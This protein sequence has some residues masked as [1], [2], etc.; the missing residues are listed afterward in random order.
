MKATLKLIKKM[1][2]IVGNGKNGIWIKNELIFETTDNYP[3]KVCISVWGDKINITEFIE[4]DTYAVDFDIES[5][6]YNGKW[7]TDLKAWKIEG[8]FTK[9]TEIKHLNHINIIDDFDILPF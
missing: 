8:I 7:F 1:P 3:K 9:E 6:E 2:Q 4:G 5:K